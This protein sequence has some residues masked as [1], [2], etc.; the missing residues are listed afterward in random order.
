MQRHACQTNR[1]VRNA[2]GYWFRDFTR[3]GLPLVLLMLA[4]LSWLLARHYRL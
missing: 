3:V 2:A 1:L 4:T